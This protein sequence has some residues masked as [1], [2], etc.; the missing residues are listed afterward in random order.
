MM[1]LVTAG[2]VRAG[3][4]VRQLRYYHDTAAGCKLAGFNATAL[5]RAGG[6][7]MRT[8]KEARSPA[9][10]RAFRINTAVANDQHEA[11]VDRAVAQ[12]WEGAF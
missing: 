6:S 9:D 11:F 5:R 10:I 12:I 3:E 8:L 4:Q 1:R 2:F 7:A